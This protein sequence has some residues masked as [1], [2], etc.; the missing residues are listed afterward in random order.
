MADDNRKP[1]AA[2][3]S[4]QSH[5]VPVTFSTFVLGLST[6]AL[7]HLGEIADPTS[8]QVNVDLNA[9][10]QTIDI[11]GV[12]EVKTRGNLDEAERGLVESV[13]YDLRMKFVE[14]TRRRA[15]EAT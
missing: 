7:L 9:A 13:L 12:L 10:K 4:G 1:G 2:S 6:Q 5:D 14:V 8:G 11:L 15:K 3:A